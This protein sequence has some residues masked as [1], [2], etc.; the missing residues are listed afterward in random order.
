[1]SIKM[2]VT[3]GAS[4]IGSEFVRQSVSKGYKVVILDKLTYAGDMAR[5]KDIRSKI[6]FHKVDICD[7]KKMIKLFKQEKPH[8]VVH[9]AAES[10]VDR[11]ILGSDEFI[12]TNISGTQSILDASRIPSLKKF[13]HM[14]TDEVYGDIDVGQFY[15]TTSLNP[16]SPYSASKAAAD[17]FVKAYMRT[18]EIPA[19]I[20]RPS[21]NYG[22]W[23]YPEKF[24]PVVIYKALRNERV[25]IYGKGINVREWLYVADCASAIWHVMEKG[26]V[27]QI[28]NI[29]SGSERKNIEVAHAILSLLDKP[30]SLIEHVT[31]RRGHDLRYSVDFNKIKDELGWRPS[32]N[33]ETGLQQTVTWYKENIAWLTQK[34]NFLKTYWKKVYK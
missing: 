20:V 16:S 5:L 26:V 18:F 28:Y 32:V 17:L 3:G 6:K 21:N 12:R 10:H 9:F 13:I 22:P 30:S 1:M 19:I 11:S 33:F 24:I 14:S 23:Q 29:G 15:E 34:A 25:P 8:T 27:G 2:I 4:F 7:K 31:D